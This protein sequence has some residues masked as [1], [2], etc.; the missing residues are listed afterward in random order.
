MG[1]A[2][3]G[4]EG[5]SGKELRE[6]ERRGEEGREGGSNLKVWLSP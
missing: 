4:R 6:E 3:S 1:K 5:G 2:R